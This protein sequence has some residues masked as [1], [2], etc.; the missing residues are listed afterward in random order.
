MSERSD[1]QQ[2][3][4]IPGGSQTPDWSLDERTRRVGRQGIAAARAALRSARP[5]EPK[6]V[7]S[8]KAS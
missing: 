1:Q 7:P 4:L 2:L 8:R 6:Q 5:P 3:R